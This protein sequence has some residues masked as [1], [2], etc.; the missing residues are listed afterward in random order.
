MDDDGVEWIWYSDDNTRLAVDE[1]NLYSLT[2]P[3][4]FGRQYFQIVGTT[5]Y[6]SEAQKYIDGRPYVCMRL[7]AVDCS[8]DNGKPYLVAVSNYAGHLAGSDAG[9]GPEQFGSNP[10]AGCGLTPHIEAV[11]VC[12]NC[13]SQNELIAIDQPFFGRWHICGHCAAHVY[14]CLASASGPTQCKPRGELPWL[15]LS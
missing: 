9:G 2:K 12:V 13:H 14:E 7:N 1:F 6:P 8:K 3:D 4:E 5:K 10:A 11:A 15:N